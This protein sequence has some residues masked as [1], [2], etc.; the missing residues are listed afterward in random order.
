[1]E[2]RIVPLKDQVKRIIVDVVFETTV[3]GLKQIALGYPSH[4]KVGNTL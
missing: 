1:M 4:L 2:V 3:I